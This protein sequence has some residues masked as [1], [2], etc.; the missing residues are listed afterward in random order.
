MLKSI[1]R[2]NDLVEGCRIEGEILL[3]GKDIFKDMDVNHAEK[4]GGNGVPETQSL[5][6]E[7]L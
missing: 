7:Y 3:D 1:N 6:Y 4:T 5:P 2:M